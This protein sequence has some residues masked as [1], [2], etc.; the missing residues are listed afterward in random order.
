MLP[1]PEKETDIDFILFSSC[2]LSKA[3]A[4]SIAPSICDLRAS[5][6][7]WRVPSMER[8]SKFYGNNNKTKKKCWK[9]LVTIRSFYTSRALKRGNTQLYSSPASKDY[10]REKTGPAFFLRV[11]AETHPSV[12]NSYFSFHRVV[13]QSRD[14]RQKCTKSKT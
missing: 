7:N 8:P 9:C 6:I 14:L 11:Q 12:Q 10:G 4:K 2:Q 13:L 3:A 1:S 5:S